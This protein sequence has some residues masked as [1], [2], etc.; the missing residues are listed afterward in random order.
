MYT[1]E[2][3][4]VPPNR[5]NVFITWEAQMKTMTQMYEESTRI[6]EGLDYPYN[7][8]GRQAYYCGSLG[9]LTAIQSRVS[10]GETF[11]EALSNTLSEL[12]KIHDIN[13]RLAESS[14]PNCAGKGTQ[15]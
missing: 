1:T 9:A 6:F 5:R 8:L 14:A 10:N 12:E 11:A 2:S 15:G 3:L 13:K 7:A 4:S